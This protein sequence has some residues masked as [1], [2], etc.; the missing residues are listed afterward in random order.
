MHLTK[1]EILKWIGV[2]FIIASPIAAYFHY[3][4]QFLLILSVGTFLWF[5]AGIITKDRPMIFVNCVSTI[6][7]IAAY[8]NN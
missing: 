6:L 3:I 8:L 4:P 7:N 2:A 5:I 1:L